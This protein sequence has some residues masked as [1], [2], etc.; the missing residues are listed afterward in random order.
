MAQI[1]QNKALLRELRIK[2]GLNQAEMADALTET[3][4]DRTGIR[5]FIQQPDICRLE[6]GAK[7][8]D[9]LKLLAYSYFCG[10]EVTTLLNHD[11]NRLV[12]PAD[13]D[14]QLREFN[15]DKSAEAH[16]V[17]LEKK[18]RLVVSPTFPSAFFRLEK[19]GVR[20]Q[21]LNSPAYEA[22]ELCTF[23]SLISFL[24][25]PVGG[26]DIARKK[27]VI[28]AY[29]NYFHRNNFRQLN[30]FSRSVLPKHYQLTTM[31]LLPE[32]KMMLI[33]GPICHY[34]EGDSFIEIRDKQVYE[35]ATH[36][37]RSLPTFENSMLY[38]R[39][40]LKA[41]DHMSDGSLARDAINQFALNILSLGDPN[42]LQAIQSFTPEIQQMID[43]E[44]AG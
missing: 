13:S 34:E 36:F 43:A 4:M 33:P 30:F 20:H 16:L 22:N 42:A 38:L 8:I 26:Y 5:H 10:V 44:K 40:G 39:Q 6:N 11:Y 19:S 14:M 15:T 1:P 28:M 24:F 23:D 41:L 37:Y 25:S 29:L 9:V 12:N 35:R 3:F 18:G 32:K 21:Q 31:V 27:E 7:A 2:K 17:T